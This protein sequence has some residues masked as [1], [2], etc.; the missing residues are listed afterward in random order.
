MNPL[1]LSAIGAT[2]FIVGAIIYCLSTRRFWVP[3][4]VALILSGL[5]IAAIA[6]DFAR[7]LDI[8]KTGG[9]RAIYTYEPYYADDQVNINELVAAIERFLEDI[10]SRVR[11]LPS[12]KIEV[13]IG[14]DPSS[15]AI[16]AVI[17]EL[18]KKN[19]PLEFRILAQPHADDEIIK[20][21][22][23]SADHLVV[24]VTGAPQA[25]W[26]RAGPY[27]LKNL[28]H[29]IEKDEAVKRDAPSGETEVLV[30]F[31]PHNLTSRFLKST[32][33]AYDSRGKLVIEFE[34][35]G[36][37]ENRMQEITR[38]NLPLGNR[39]RHLAII[40]DEMIYSAPS[41][42]SIITRKGQITGDFTRKEVDD[43]VRLLGVRTLPARLHLQEDKT[44]TFAL[45]K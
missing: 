1:L 3:M 27:F 15:A 2:V 41:I 35:T 26:V 17:E 4:I 33:A 16:H 23:A 22:T 5:W 20:K 7:P 32:E 34:L 40:I 28:D 19:D 9:V 29:R 39:C 13:S 45:P 43:L 38:N 24:D 30:L 25:K 12:G 21:A 6:T 10:P 31:D 8:T 18:D 37:G 36:S 44:E 14:G 11:K 42:Q